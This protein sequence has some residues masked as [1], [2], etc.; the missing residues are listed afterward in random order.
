MSLLG[1]VFS[2]NTKSIFVQI[3]SY[4]DSELVPTVKDLFA[5]A[6]HPLDL[7]V[8]IA[9]QHSSEESIDE[10][11]HIP[12]VEI[13]DIDYKESKGVCWA[14]NQ[15]NQR[16][17]REKYTLQID[18]HCRF[19]K[20]WDTQLIDMYNQVKKEDNKVILSTYPSSYNPKN[21]PQERNPY[22]WAINFDTHTKDG[23]PTL[24]P[25]PIINSEELTEPFPS[26]YLAG[27]F[28]FTEGNFIRE[29]PYDPNLYFEGEEISLSVRAYTHGYDIYCPHK[30]I[31]WHHYLRENDPKHW[32]DN[33]E[34]KGA[35]FA[36]ID[37][38]KKLLGIDGKVCTPCM[39]RG[40]GVYY[41]GKKRT[42][43]QY[44][45]F[46]GFHFRSRGVDQY[47]VKGNLPPNPVIERFDEHYM[48]QQ[49]WNIKIHRELI[50]NQGENFDFISLILQDE[51]HYD[52]Y[53]IDFD[54]SFIKT[55][56]EDKNEILDINGHYNGRP[57]KY[58]VLWPHKGKWLQKLEGI[59]I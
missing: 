13:I 46:S 16:Y 53:R 28:L 19:V 29:V 41:L 34:W 15:I 59:K 22:N 6:D 58:W 54:S 25:V 17:S 11:K 31:I 10:I 7:R 8:V 18:S 32:D 48:P 33:P 55:M 42:L 39:Q 49:S 9:W 5:N 36:S 3:A 2:K 44:E 57:Y 26:R 51:N 45:E 14:R 20:G 50:E 47:T 21:D 1:Q 43:R 38:I 24:K 52:V 27:G 56:L 30:L 40:M 4:R 37:R 23:I 12:G 35:S